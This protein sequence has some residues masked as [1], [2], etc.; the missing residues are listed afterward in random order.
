MKGKAMKSKGTSPLMLVADRDDLERAQL[1]AILS[2]K[3]L[4]VIE[5][6]DGPAA[7][8]LAIAQVPDLLLLDLKLPRLRSSEAIWKIRQEPKLQKM[9]IVAVSA[10]HTGRIPLDSLTVHASRPIEFGILD[11]FLDR[12]LQQLSSDSRLRAEPQPSHH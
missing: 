5:A 3:G 12:F 10:H 11:S 2:F 8:E 7:I 1:R 6:G 4:R 9:P